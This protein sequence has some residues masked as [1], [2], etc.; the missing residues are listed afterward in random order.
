MEISELASKAFFC[1][2]TSEMINTRTICFHLHRT[3]G[4]LA[5]K[6][7]YN[8]SWQTSNKT[9]GWRPDSSNLYHCRRQPDIATLL[10]LKWNRFWGIAQVSSAD[11][12]SQKGFC[13]GLLLALRGHFGPMWAG[14]CADM[15]LP[16]F[17]NHSSVSGGFTHWLRTRVAMQA[18]GTQ[19]QLT[20]PQ[21]FWKT[22]FSEWCRYVQGLPSLS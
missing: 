1:S 2:M 6:T 7:I 15:Q 4:S 10:W 5:E 16:N 19:W 14:G 13:T 9:K 18:I 8:F 11:L 17:L 20:I 3:Q 12:R 22:H 21:S